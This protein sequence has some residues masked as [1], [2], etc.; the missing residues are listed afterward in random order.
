MFLTF[1][2]EKR[3]FEKELSVVNPTRRLMHFKKWKKWKKKNCNNIMEK[4]R[5]RVVFIFFFFL[6]FYTFRN[7][8]S[9]ITKHRYQTKSV[10]VVVAFPCA[11]EMH[12]TIPSCRQ[13]NPHKSSNVFPKKNEIVI[14]DKIVKN[15]M[16]FDRMKKNKNKDKREKGK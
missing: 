6:F 5:F 10:A 2:M 3:K 4:L 15:R 16:K 12:Y 1:S 14:N 11:Y 9:S 7:P 13:T 8:K